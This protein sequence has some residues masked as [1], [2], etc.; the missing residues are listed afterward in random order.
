MTDVPPLVHITVV[1]VIG[2]HELRNHF[3]DGTVGD[4]A[5]A[6]DEWRG[7]FEPLRDSAFFAQVGVDREIGTIVWPG[8]LDMA[9]EP[10]YEEARRNAVTAPRGR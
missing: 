7:V 10:R 2:D 3:E 5:F 1:A 8:E 6:A 9:P 4:I